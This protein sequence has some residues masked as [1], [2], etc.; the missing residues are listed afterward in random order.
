MKCFKIFIFSTTVCDLISFIQYLYH[1]HACLHR[2]AFGYHHNP[3]VSFFFKFLSYHLYFTPDLTVPEKC[4]F[5]L[6][7]LI[8]VACVI[9]YACLC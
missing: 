5:I 1:F 3:S 8:L 4:I 6:I 2:S 9:V 7:S